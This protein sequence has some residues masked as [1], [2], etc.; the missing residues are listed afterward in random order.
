MPLAVE[1]INKNS[2]LGAVRSAISR[3]IEYLIKHEGKSSKEAAGQAYAQAAER[4]GRKIPRG[5]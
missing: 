2:S 5:N 1:K 4:W 3:T